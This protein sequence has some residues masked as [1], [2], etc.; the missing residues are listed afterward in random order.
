MTLALKSGT[1]EEALTA[2]TKLTPDVLRDIKLAALDLKTFRVENKKMNERIREVIEAANAEKARIEEKAEERID[3]I[4]QPD[5]LPPGVIQRG[6]V[7][8]AE[9]RK[10]SVGEKMAGRQGSTGRTARMAREGGVRGWDDGQVPAGL[11]R[12]TARSAS[13]RPAAKSLPIAQPVSISLRMH[14][15]SRT[16]TGSK[17]DSVVRR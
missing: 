2:G 17:P 11:V 15:A 7:Y 12:R 16:R 9:K 1:V 8:L 13:E 4:L 5:E 6:K 3:K 14:S 10:I